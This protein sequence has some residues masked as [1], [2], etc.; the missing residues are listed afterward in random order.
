VALDVDAAAAGAAGQL[1]VLAR[2]E[3]HAG[4]A[5]ELLQLLEHDR[6]RRHVD[7]EG[8]RLRGED[9][10]HQLLLE[11]LLD[12]LLER[13]QEARVVGR[14][15]ALQA[16]EPLVVA[17]DGEVGVQEG[18]A[19][20]L[21]DGADLV[22]LV[23]FREVDARAQHLLHGGVAAGPA[24]DEEDRGQQVLRPQQL[25][26]VGAQHL[27]LVGAGPAASSAA[28][29]PA[30]AVRPRIAA[31]HAGQPGELGIHPVRRGQ[32]GGVEE[33]EHLVP[34]EHVLVERDRPL[35]AH[36][37]VGLATHDLQPVAE[38]L[39][40]RHGGGQRDEPH[41]LREVDDDLLPDRAAEPVG[42]VVHLVHHDEGE[43][44]EQ[45]GVRVEH[46][47]QHLGRHDHDARAGV[48][49]RVA[50]Q[51][52]DLVRAV[53]AH[54]L[55][56]LLVAQ[57]LHGRGVEDLVPRLLHRQ[58]DRELGDDGLACAGGGGDEHAPAVLERLAGA[59]LER[60]EVEL[61][62]VAERIELRPGGSSAG[63][64][65]PLGWALLVGR[66]ERPYS[67]SSV[68]TRRDLR[69]SLSTA[70]PAARR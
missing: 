69:L 66:H 4:L 42:E 22:T 56:E 58:V 48:D 19:A 60:V 14:D 38:L 2:G 53:L 18:A 63:G 40:V 35:L 41:R 54:E 13:R 3:R 59:D 29:S 24:E 9:G 57:R 36:D 46:V 49:V 27:A 34:H 44:G 20:L 31:A 16:L 68:F 65:I 7:A 28:A 67:A 64:G 17:E 70:M 45:V 15:A 39:G 8:Q 47:A 1:R 43:V 21:D 10:L 12:D 37:H 5:V 6:A 23:L 26:D 25:D 62:P 33:V 61:L 32:A 51:Q 52:A 50:G 30:A 55:G 11:E